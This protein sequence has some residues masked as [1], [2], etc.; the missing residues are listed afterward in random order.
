MQGIFPSCGPR[1]MWQ[2]KKGQRDATLL[3]LKM[4]MRGP[5]A[6][7]C[8]WPL[9]TRKGQEVDAPVESLERNVSPADALILA[10]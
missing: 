8:E 4:G 9:T 2:Q 5:R 1:Q 6:K 3:P 7:E 10:Q